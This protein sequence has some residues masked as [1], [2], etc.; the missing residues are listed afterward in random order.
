MPQKPRKS[1][2]KPRPAIPSPP[3][4]NVAMVGDKVKVYSLQSL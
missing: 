2:P 4:V 1:P 3:L